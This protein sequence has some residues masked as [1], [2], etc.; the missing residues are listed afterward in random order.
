[1]LAN[2]PLPRVLYIDLA[3]RRAWVQVR[4]DLFE[5]GLG[6]A[7]VGIRLLMEECPP[8]ADPLGPENPIILTVGPLVGLFPLASKTVATFKSPHTGN[9]GESH[10]GGRSAIAIRM[11]GYGAIVIRGKSSMPVYLVIDGDQVHFRDAS[12]LWGLHNSYTA[13]SVLRNREKGTGERTILRIGKAGEKL[14]TYAGVIAE[15]YRHFGRLGLGAV[16]GSKMLKALVISG[17]RTLPV[18]DKRA[19]RTTYDELFKAATESELMKKYHQL[20]TAAAWPARTA[21]WRAS[22]WRRCARNIP[23]TRTSTRPPWSA[24]T[25]SRS[26]PRAAC[27]ASARCRACWR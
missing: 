25:T 10:A 14:V 1:M 4:E 16:F 26:S 21:R 2:D 7:G 8:G 11:A 22:T 19:Y 20:G 18:A 3:K 5:A 9:L 24:M 15:S 17:R 12:A 6:G 27:W 13:G 23:T